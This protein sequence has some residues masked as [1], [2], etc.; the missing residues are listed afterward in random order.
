MKK[1]A[2][3]A[4]LAALVAAPAMAHPGSAADHADLSEWA[5]FALTIGPAFLAGVA[6]TLVAQRLRRA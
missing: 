1:L 4:A 5:H 2:S 6:L 3:L